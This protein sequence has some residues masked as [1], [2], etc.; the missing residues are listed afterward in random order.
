MI[1]PFIALGI[2]AGLLRRR[3]GNGPT[4]AFTLAWSVLFGLVVGS[5]YPGGPVQVFFAATALALVN[6]AVGAAVGVALVSVARMTSS[7]VD[8]SR[9]RGAQGRHVD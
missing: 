3:F 5:M 1:L 9:S 4:A 6:A 7:S 2:A 8:P